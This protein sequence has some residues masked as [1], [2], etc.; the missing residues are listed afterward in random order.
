MKVAVCRE[1]GKPL[2][3]EYASLAPVGAGQVHVK[4][5]ACAICHSDIMFAT[6]A[7]GGH[8]PAVYGHEAAGTVLSVGTGV[9]G[10]AAGDAVLVTLIR[11][12]GACPT[13]ADGHP[14]NCETAYDR[15]ASSPLRGVDGEVLEH[16]LATAAFA[17]EVV[18]DQSQVIGLP[19]GIAMDAASLLACGAITGIGAVIN[20]AA[21]PKGAS[22]VVVGVGGVGLN[23][24][25]GAVLAGASCVIALDI[26]QSK[27]DGALEFGATHAVNATDKD[28]VAQIHAINGGRGVDYVFVTVGAIAA[29]NAALDYLG[30]RGELVMVGMTASGQEMG[31]EPVEV[32]GNS[33]VLR[34]TKMGDTLL[35][36]D[37]PVLLEHYFAGRLK[38]DELISNRYPLEQ[39][40][41]AIADTKAGISRR[42]V[43]IFD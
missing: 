10:V 6:G 38:L 33:Q 36:R 35:S 21:M 24:V 32:A 40:N 29:Y 26:S 41:E 7:W 5:A 4:V 22:A 30:P 25:Q 13:C 19:E 2:V 27:L 42:N 39:I 28:V 43:I 8:L 31:I 23:T 15:V 3:I 14:T 17:Q 20:A 34:G 9:Q 18:V 11:S 1:F 16:G 37:I 12:C